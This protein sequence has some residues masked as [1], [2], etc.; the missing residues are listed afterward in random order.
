VNE[1]E[2]PY[3]INASGV[4]V[5]KP[6]ERPD[7][8]QALTCSGGLRFFQR[9][10]LWGLQNEKR[11]TVIEPRYRALS[12]FS[13]GVAWTASPRAR[14]WCPIGPDG[15]RSEAL[16]CRE[17]F[18]PMM[19]TE[20]SPEKFS[21]DRYENSVLWTRAFLDYLAGNRE[22]PPR[23]V[24]RFGANTVAPGPALGEPV[25]D[26][27]ITNV[28]KAPLVGAVVIGALAVV[29]IKFSLRNSKRPT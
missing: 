11:E 21:E 27:A 23:W 10:G 4:R 26:F 13:Q 28:V 1:G 15:K 17:T 18:Y 5:D 25:S 6:S 20:S 8:T 3:W 22:T 16:E 29:L 7:P 19:V 24:S 12:C 9:A 2:N 14:A